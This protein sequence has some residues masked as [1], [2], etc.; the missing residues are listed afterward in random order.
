VLDSERNDRCIFFNVS[1]NAHTYKIIHFPCQQIVCTIK[2]T[3]LFAINVIDTIISIPLYLHHKVLYV[4]Y[5]NK[6]YNFELQI[7]CMGVVKKIK[8]FN[9]IEYF[10]IQ[11][12][13]QNISP[14]GIM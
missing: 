9:R 11:T 13:E 6:L 3:I 7:N 4:Y 10:S 5:N 8:I 14:I 12:T 2:A 1:H